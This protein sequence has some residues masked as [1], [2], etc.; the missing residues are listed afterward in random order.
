[1][2]F[3]CYQINRKKDTL[4]NMRLFQLPNGNTFFFTYHIKFNTPAISPC[5][6]YVY[7]D[8]DKC[9]IGYIGKHLPTAKF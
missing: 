9:Y 5:R 1:M 4:H 8:G 3:I 6:I 7:P 2:R